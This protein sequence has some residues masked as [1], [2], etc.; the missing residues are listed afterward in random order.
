MVGC[1]VELISTPTVDVPRIT[2]ATAAWLDVVG[3]IRGSCAARASD[4]SAL[5]MVGGAVGLLRGPA[6]VVW[7]HGD[8]DVR[9][10]THVLAASPEVREV[11]VESTRSAVVD[12]LVRSGWNCT[13]V[14][15][16]V[17]RRCGDAAADC[18]VTA[19]VV[20]LAVA[21]V[22]EMRRLIA[23]S[24]PVDLQQ[25]E[26]SYPDDFFAVA[27]PVWAFG[28]RDADRLVAM[29]A[30]RRQARSAMGF[31]LNVAPDF[32]RRGLATALVHAAARQ[33][34]AAGAEFVHAL[35]TGEGV[36]P[37]RECGFLTA[38]VWQRLTRD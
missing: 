27:A 7:I 30:V 4:A 24:G 23:E 16:Q 31:A 11:F 34:F 12:E 15:A 26:A 25:L 1:R 28:V 29:V 5:L 13:Q 38:G 14:L 20:P 10:L 37:L 32:R 33:G 22:P 8:T 17:V 19:D 3:E 9:Q 36:Y 21:D 6:P 18:A 2:P 35:A